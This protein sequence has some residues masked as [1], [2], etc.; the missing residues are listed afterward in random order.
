MQ[1]CVYISTFIPFYIDEV[2]PI[3]GGGGVNA[4]EYRY[5]YFKKVG[6][7]HYTFNVSQDS[8]ECVLHP[9]W[10]YVYFWKKSTHMHDS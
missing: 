9:M 7:I 1:I 2:Y 4:G 6:T 10:N 3:G 5:A 8:I